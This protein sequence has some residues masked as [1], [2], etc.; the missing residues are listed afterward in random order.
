ML[1]NFD[2][3]EVFMIRLPNFFMTHPPRRLIE[4]ADLEFGVIIHLDLEVF[5]PTWIHQVNGKLSPPPPIESFNPTELDTDQWI[6]AVKASG[7]KYAVLTA[8]HVVGFTLFPDKNYPFSIDKTPYKGGK[9]NIVKDFINSCHK[10]GILPGLYYSCEANSY[11]KIHKGSGNLPPYP[12]K[13]WTYFTELVTRHLTHLWSEYG[14]LCEIWFDGGLLEHGPDIP[15]LLQKFQPNAVAFQ[16]PEQHPYRLRWVGNERGV[17]PYPCWSTIMSTESYDGTQEIGDKNKG[18]P[19]G[20]YWVPAETDVPLRF[21]QWFWQPNQDSLAA[22]SGYIMKWYYE[23]VG[24]N[25]NILLGLV[26]D[27]KGLI[28]DSD[29]KILTEFGNSLLNRFQN[30]IKIVNGSG[31]IISMSLPSFT[32]VNMIEL[33][34]DISQGHQIREFIIEGKDSTGKWLDIFN[35]SAIGHRFLHWIPEK[36]YSELKIRITKSLGNPIIKRFAIYK[37]EPLEDEFE[38]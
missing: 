37:A 35:G 10:Y 2:K 6:K 27:Q 22:S 15:G 20:K 31:E 26:I 36:S 7:A 16:G 28:P 9:G 8:K 24:R 34:E 5:N 1:G 38:E 11:L 17:A 29:V 12:S 23:S 33:M 21:M 14:E 32:I 30:P 25:S 4:W 18:D 13:E 3:Q 19:D